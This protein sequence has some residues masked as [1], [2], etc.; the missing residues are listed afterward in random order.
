M[1]DPP[2]HPPDGPTGLVREFTNGLLAGPERL[3]IGPRVGLR[4]LHGAVIVHGHGRERRPFTAVHG[5]LFTAGC[6]AFTGLPLLPLPL[7]TA[8]LL[9]C[10]LLAPFTLGP[11]ALLLFTFEL[12]GSFTVGP[13]LLLAA[14]LLGCLPLLA[15][16]LLL[17]LST[18]PLKLGK[19]LTF[20]AALLTL[21]LG[22]LSLD[23][24]GVFTGFPVRLFTAF[25]LVFT[26]GAGLFTAGLFFRP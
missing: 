19:V 17:A 6:R 3:D 13:L 21:A 1:A 26:V 24:L 4:H 15:A 16:L 18:L 23:L 25:S 10:L 9:G 11:L 20:L 14:G 22:P 2:G 8:G 5:G 7:F 12:L